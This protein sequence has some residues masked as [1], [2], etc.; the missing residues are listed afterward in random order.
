M[1]QDI[2]LSLDNISKKYSGVVALDNVSLE[3]KRGEIH[4]LIGEN[5]AGKSTL[6]KTVAG[7]INPDVGNITIDGK[8]FKYM[9]PQL[10]E[11]M[12]IATIYQEFNLVDE[13]SAAENIF[14]GKKLSKGIFINKKLMY[15]KA[16]QVFEQLN[17]DIPPDKLVKNL[18]VGYQQMVEIAKAVI[19]NAKV[20]IMDEP[21]AP[22]TVVEIESM[23]NL[24]HELN[25]RNV[26]II[27]ISHRLDEVFRISNRITVMRD[28]KKISTLNTKD[29]NVDELI[30]LMVGRK[31]SETFPKR[32]N[33]S[34]NDYLLE[35]NNLS[36]NGIRN[37]SFKLKRGE[38]LGF[39]GLIGSGRTELMELIFGAKKITKGEIIFNGKKYIPKN[40]KYSIN[41]GIVLVPED[42]K[43]LGALITRSIKENITISCIDKISKF[44]FI[45]NKLDKKISNNF[46][47]K[48]K[49]KTSSINQIVKN[50]SGGNQQKVVIS[51]CLSVNP[52]LIIL[53][54]PTRGIDVGAKYEIYKLINELILEGKT[55]IYISSEM[56]ELI[57]MSDRI[58]VL[59]EGS[60]VGEIPKEKFSQ[61][62]IMS[63]AAAID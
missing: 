39:A 47:K 48:L 16:K 43:K 59:F 22:L 40:P 34:S 9:T 30:S 23:F 54:E 49:I 29:S 35:V 20:L 38:I 58:I 41:N 36:G 53:D 6:I 60:M 46:I 13:L 2:I 11:E 1:E 51:K 62:L 45:N 50:L 63:Y 17:I 21:S 5:G 61:N 18:T 33:N 19:Q 32:E 37:I 10:S 31:M 7:A 14:L 26:S 3:I 42:R 27:Y 12:G 55:I 57:G 4:A 56:E 44:I 8:S 24:I 52:D 25:K 15:K 28:G